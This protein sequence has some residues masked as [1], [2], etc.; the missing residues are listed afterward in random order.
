VGTDSDYVDAYFVLDT[1]TRNRTDFSNYDALKNSAA[2]LGV[3]L[4]FERIYDVYKRYRF[5][6]FDLAVA[7]VAVAPPLALGWRVLAR[8]VRLRKTIGMI[9]P[10]RQQS[11]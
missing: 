8:I 9:S 3:A 1:Q 4:K 10:P 5:T 11:V 7:F 2:Q 6:W